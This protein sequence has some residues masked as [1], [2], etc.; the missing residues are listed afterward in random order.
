[1]HASLGAR[2]AG[3]R[4]GLTPVAE[5]LRRA[6]ALAL[7]LAVGCS[8]HSFDARFAAVRP[9]DSQSQVEASLGKSLSRTEETLPST[10]LF[11][12]AE[13]LAGVLEPGASYESWLYRSDRQDYLVFFAG[14]PGSR[15]DEWRVV[16]KERYPT[17][18]V[19][20]AT[21]RSR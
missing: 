1:M 16:G 18:A 5:T 9:G 3:T 7:L 14:K 17:G 21:P 2:H 8:Q 4:E 11:G 20:E 10:P 12:P 6:A 19:F 13:G 15:K